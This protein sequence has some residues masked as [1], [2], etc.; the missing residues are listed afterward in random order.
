MAH[1]V[2]NMSKKKT[3]R[4]TLTIMGAAS[5]ATLAACGSSENAGTG[6]GATA[7][8]GGGT[9]GAGGGTT[10]TGAGGA[11]GA[12]T[13]TGGG[14]TGGGVADGGGVQCK[15]KVESTVGPFPNIDPLERRDLRGNT[16]G[17]MTPK[18]GVS[19]TLRV[20]VYDLSNNCAPIP[21][22]V[23]DIWHCDAVG[24]YSGY[25]NFNTPGQD[26]G[27]G[28]QRTDAQGVAEFSTIFPGS[29][30][31]RAIHAHFAIQGSERN[32]TPNSHGS[33]LA[34]IFVGQLYFL[35]AIADEIWAAMPIY[36]QGAAITA[37]ES[38]S[39]FTNEGGRDLVVTM[40]K[41]GSGYVGE[42]QIGVMG[43]D[44]GK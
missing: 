8:A 40:T 22:A 29:Y 1:E 12:G 21:D 23:V 10:G 11:S 28:Y 38:D 5:L 19:L 27:R 25:A 6:T 3:R 39:F 7:G 17:D 36:Q 43:S 41:S 35:R 2:K 31:G 44:I 15:S 42:I 16:T 14:G 9:T 13:G 20:S 33:N 34:G 32:L 24:V 18:Q 37:N 4:E 26:F 30:M